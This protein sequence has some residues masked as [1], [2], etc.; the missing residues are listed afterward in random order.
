M[1][2]ASRSAR[3][4]LWKLAFY[5]LVSLVVSR[6]RPRG[7]THHR[8]PRSPQQHRAPSGAFGSSRSTDEPRQVQRQ[9]AHEHGRGRKAA[10][11]WQIPWAGWKD[12]FWRTY[13]EI[14]DDR[15]V[16]AA[17]DVVFYA[18]L[19]IYPTIAA[20]DYLYELFTDTA[21]INDHLSH[22]AGYLPQ[23]ALDI[24]EDQV[25]GITSKGDAKIGL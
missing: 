13:A 9:R 17:A 7:R 12:I 23:D 15:L 25:A 1:S 21:T 24:I 2:S 14:Q 4:S 11:P 5:S 3:P 22:T 19:A 10:S 6:R 16:A 8:P 20:S 18:H